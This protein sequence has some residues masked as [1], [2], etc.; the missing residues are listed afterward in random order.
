MAQSRLDVG[1]IADLFPEATNVLD[2]RMATGEG[3]AERC[4]YSLFNTAYLSELQICAE[5]TDIRQATLRLRLFVLHIDNSH[6]GHRSSNR[7]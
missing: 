1:A 5:M 6:S 3:L 2:A 7:I 4:A